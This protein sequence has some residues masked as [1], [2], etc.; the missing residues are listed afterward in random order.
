MVP[1]ISNLTFPEE[2]TI[3]NPNNA[4][5]NTLVNLQIAQPFK[6]TKPQ[7]STYHTTL[8]FLL[9]KWA[10]QER[11]H[12]PQM[13]LRLFLHLLAS[14]LTPQL[15]YEVPERH[16]GVLRVPAEINQLAFRFPHRF[17]QQRERVGFFT[18][19]RLKEL[20]SSDQR[21]CESFQ[22]NGAGFREG[23]SQPVSLGSE[24][25]NSLNSSV[26]GKVGDWRNYLTDEM[27]RR[28]DQIVEEKF[29]GTGLKF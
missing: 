21:K 28:L 25:R 12:S 8:F 13:S 4:I 10:P 20:F 7:D 18:F 2:H 17:G 19:F 23:V 11:R 29:K 24:L 1:P 26:K 22:P 16:H 15:I 9:R 3:L 14:K 5:N 6:A 27:A